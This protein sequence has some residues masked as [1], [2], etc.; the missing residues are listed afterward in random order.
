MIRAYS[1]RLTPPFS[2]Q[3]QIA[4]SDD[5]RAVSMDLET[6]EIHFRRDGNRFSRGPWVRHRELAE[7]NAQ[8]VRDGVK[9]D[10]RILELTRFLVTATFP[11][12]AKD[13]FEY[14][15][16]DPKDDSPLALIFTCTDGEHMSRFPHRPEWT[17]LPAAVMP[18]EPTPD[19]KA[20]SV[21]PVNYRLE[22]RVAERAGS[23]PQA[24]W[25]HRRPGERDVF[26]S[27]MIRE[28]WSDPADAELC[29]RY[30]DRQAS[31]LLMLHGLGATDRLRLE[32]A[33]RAQAL[34]VH[35]FHPLYPQWADE[36]LMRGILVEARIR[37]A[38]GEIDDR[39][40]RRDG[41]LYL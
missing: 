35:R 6:W 34:E 23:K 1:Q 32:Q 8:G 31:R 4:E 36:T 2:G 19:E 26:P 12:P 37:I 3:V 33:A 29:R 22:R 13:S 24:R 27:L 16:L 41:V 9:V 30:L 18:V 10:E 5:A 28:D 20:G 25:F 14:W 17:A 11:F 21:P 39:L 40:N 15:L 38:G 7:I